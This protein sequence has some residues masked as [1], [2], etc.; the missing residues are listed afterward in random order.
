ME[1]A[2]AIRR[3]ELDGVPGV[4][5]P[6]TQQQQLVSNYIF[7]V[8]LGSVAQGRREQIRQHLMDAGI[9]TSVHYPAVHRFSIYE[10]YGASLPK[11]E[12]VAYNLITLPMYSGL[13][14][15]QVVEIVARLRESLDAAKA[16]S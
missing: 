11:T 3:L 4:I 2:E 1:E 15:E 8:V 12:Y 6:F 13:Q 14:K 10:P 9:Q 16:E 5:V 7:P